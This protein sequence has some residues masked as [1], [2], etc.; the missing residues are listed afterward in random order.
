[1]NPVSC[2]NKKTTQSSTL[3]RF[4]VFYHLC[5]QVFGA[6]AV[7]QCQKQNRRLT[8]RELE[9]LTCTG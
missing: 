8:L 9:S 1:M 2:I 3:G 6:I 5:R 4:Q 7:R